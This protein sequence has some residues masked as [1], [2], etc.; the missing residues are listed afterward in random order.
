M[1]IATVCW[2][3]RNVF[4]ILAFALYVIGAVFSNV[5]GIQVFLLEPCSL[6]FGSFTVQKGR[7]SFFRAGI[8]GLLLIK[9]GLDTLHDKRISYWLLV[10]FSLLVIQS[11]VSQARGL[12]FLFIFALAA[13]NIDIKTICRILFCLLTASIILIAFLT[14][15]GVIKEVISWGG[16]WYRPVRRSLGFTN[17]NTLALYL[18][19]LIY[20]FYVLFDLKAKTFLVMLIVAVFGFF[21]SGSRGLILG[22]ISLF[23]SHSLFKFTNLPARCVLLFILSIIVIADLVFLYQF[24]CGPVEEKLNSLL[25]YRFSY[26]CPVLQSLPVTWF[27]DP[28]AFVAALDQ[29]KTFDN[30]FAYFLLV[31]GLVGTAILLLSFFIGMLKD[32]DNIKLLALGSTICFVGLIESYM[33]D[34][35]MSF[36]II[37]IILDGW[38]TQF[39][40]KST[41]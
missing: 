26:V 10:I 38:D 33:A 6:S 9:I 32:L 25:S 17:Q 1:M 28:S 29:H 4:F 13:R 40:R 27:G 12:L 37:K 3:R 21:I 14:L 7:I 18:L 19:A 23:V 36:P 31:Y 41:I 5:E 39:P 35:V 16:E 24:S 20:S 34:P 22:F 15:N 30:S 2:K 11:F 8:Y